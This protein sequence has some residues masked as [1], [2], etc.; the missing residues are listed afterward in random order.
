M[1]SDVTSD[2]VAP[3][4]ALLFETANRHDSYEKAAPAHDWWDWYAAYMHARGDGRA[5]DEAA[6]YANR[7][8]AEVKHVALPG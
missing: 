6:T 5:P 2:H 4:A 1:S 3:L 8:M 7:Y